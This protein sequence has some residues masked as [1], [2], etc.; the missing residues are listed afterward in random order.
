M[1][2]SES[3]FVVT[4]IPGPN[5]KKLWIGAIV[6]LAI[7]LIGSSLVIHAK[8]NDKKASGPQEASAVSSLADWKVFTTS[9]YSYEIP[10]DAVII[11]QTTGSF[12]NNGEVYSLTKVIAPKYPTLSDWMSAQSLQLSEYTSTAEAGHPAYQAIAGQRIYFKSG[13]TVYILSGSVGN[14]IAPNPT[15]PVWLHFLNT[16][17]LLVTS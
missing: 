4:T 12:S 16:L 9:S 17:H 7:I 11:N 15:D 13:D 10:G 8:R 5:R 1:A 6:L 3:S 2:E 14:E